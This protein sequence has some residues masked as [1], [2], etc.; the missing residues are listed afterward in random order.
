M[1]SAFALRVV[2][3]LLLSEQFW[4]S[5][6]DVQ[7]YATD[8]GHNTWL[9][10][11]CESKKLLTRA[12]ISISAPCTLSG[13]TTAKVCIAFCGTSIIHMCR[14]T[15]GAERLFQLFQLFTDPFPSHILL[16]IDMVLQ[17]WYGFNLVSRSQPRAGQLLVLNTQARI[18]DYT[19]CGTELCHPRGMPHATRDG[20]SS[21]WMR[22]TNTTRRVFVNGTLNPHARVYMAGNT[23]EG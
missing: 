10:R 4:T 9:V 7:R 2:T 6:R 16:P 11:R 5:K 13:C 3:A 21:R 19:G 17:Q 12:F 14:P 18:L 1:C 15:A 20:C 23:V 8:G 22:N